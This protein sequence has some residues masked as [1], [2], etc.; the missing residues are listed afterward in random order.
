MRRPGE[1]SEVDRFASRIADQARR[2]L[3]VEQ[4]SHVHRGGYTTPNRPDAAA[5]GVGS[6]I[7]DTT[8]HK[9]IWSDGATWRDATGTAV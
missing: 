9:P 7:Y 3:Q 5:L 2:L 8:L 1:I 6:Q 4:V